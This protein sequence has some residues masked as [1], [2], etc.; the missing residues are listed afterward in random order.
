MHAHIYIRACT[1]AR[2]YANI[3]WW[4]HTPFYS[5][6]L[7]IFFLCTLNFAGVH[8][9][10]FN[11]KTKTLFLAGNQCICPHDSYIPRQTVLFNRSIRIYILRIERLNEEPPIRSSD[12]TNPEIFWYDTLSHLYYLSDFRF[13]FSYLGARHSPVPVVFF[14]LCHQSISL[15]HQKP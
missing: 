4:M 1:N 13:Y 12:M 7:K 10:N 11:H 9:K 14:F 15:R 8:S 6:A 3:I 5:P 2:K